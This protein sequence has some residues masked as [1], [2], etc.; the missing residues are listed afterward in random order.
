MPQTPRIPTI[1]RQTNSSEKLDWA[2]TVQT[3]PPLNHAH[4]ADSRPHI[5]FDV[6]D[7]SAA[8]TDECTYKSRRA[9]YLSNTLIVR[10]NRKIPR[11][12]L[13]GIIMQRCA[14]A[15]SVFCVRAA[16]R[17]QVYRKRSVGVIKELAAVADN[18]SDRRLYLKRISSI[19]FLRG[20]CRVTLCCWPRRCCWWLVWLGPRTRRRIPSTI[21]SSTPRSTTGRLST[22]TGCSRSTRTA[23]SWRSPSAARVTLPRSKVSWALL[24]GFWGI[25]GDVRS[26]FE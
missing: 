18:Q 5:P 12:I 24:T 1:A 22:T 15:L 25:V 21:R 23:S 4:L 7:H 16:A 19:L 3:R 13:A 11:P 14:R 8:H 9:K 2:R 10:K 20:Q 26:F 17:K 6:S